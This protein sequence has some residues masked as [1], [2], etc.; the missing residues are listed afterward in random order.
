MSSYAHPEVLVNTQW[1]ADH[2]N[3]PS[4]KLL[5]VGWDASE[6]ETGHI[7]GAASGWGFADVQ[8]AETSDI[9]GKSEIERMLSQAGISNGDTIVL[10]GGIGNLIAVM[11]FILLKIY[12]YSDVRLLDGG[13]QKW[14]AEDRELSVEKPNIQSSRYAAQEPNL[15][16]RADKDYVLG[17]IK[18]TGHAIVDARS[19]EM[20]NDGRVPSAINIPASPILD[21]Q[22]NLQGWQTPT[23]RSDGTFKSIEELNAL[24]SSNSITPDKNIVTYCV[25][26]GLSSH[27]WFV[28]TQLL[29]YPSVREYYSSWAEWSNLSDVPVEK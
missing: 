9:P 11:A 27:M 7:P 22:G 24:F 19:A 2:L 28:L 29:G 13:R 6:F 26:G 21:A 12:G 1:V 17:V 5:E 16:L 18:Q 15:N 14:L 8:N 3:D 25:R 23:T 20:Y 10:Y 4:V